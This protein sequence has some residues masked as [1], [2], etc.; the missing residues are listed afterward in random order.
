MQNLQSKHWWTFT[1]RGCLAVLF[2]LFALLAWPILE[3]GLLG[4][5]LGIYILIQGVLALI[6]YLMMPKK[7]HTLPVLLE[8]VLG[9]PIGTWLLMLTDFTHPLCIVSFVVWGIGIGFCKVIHAVFLFKD[10]DIFRVLGVNGLLSILFNVVIYIQAEV[11]EKPIV[12]ILSLYF[13]VYGLLMI[14]FGAKVKA[15][16]G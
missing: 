4:A 14:F 1:I 8:S 7:A 2:G 9:I 12:W 5:F 6:A 3:L 11:T 13:V 10:H 16:Q 15:S